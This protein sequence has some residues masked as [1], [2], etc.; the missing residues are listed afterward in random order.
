[1][2]SRYFRRVSF[3]ERLYLASERRTPG[4]CI[5]LVV[6]ADGG[7]DE[8]TLRRAVEAASIANPGARLVLRGVLGFTR[9]VDEGP[10]PPVRI[11]EGWRSGARPPSDVARVLDPKTGPTC[12]V[13]LAPHEQGSRL[14]FR[15]FH[16]VMD[17]SGLLHFAQDV[18]RALRGE[19]PIGAPCM[20]NDTEFVS[21]LA[22]TKRRSFL[23]DA[24]PPL[25]GP[26]GV[27]E[28][29]VHWHRGRLPS[30]VPSLV[31]KVATTLARFAGPTARGL[32]MVP[33]DLRSYRK[34][35]ASTANRT[36]PVFLEVGAS[37]DWRAVQTSLLKRLIAKEPLRLEVAEHAALWFPLWLLSALYG[38]WVNGHR[39]KGLFPFT[40]LVTHVS[41]PSHDVLSAGSLRCR[42]VFLLPPESDFIPL[43]ISAV[44]SPA[45]TELVVSGPADLV[46]DEKLAALC[47]M[48]TRELS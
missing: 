29:S 20:Q 21:A 3:N 32:M 39:R 7:V 46:S 22:G 19:T 42:S 37:D 34:E 35:P 33:V 5:Q 47:A 11:L 6:E 45:S 24:W 4:F 25:L 23:A 10:V 44:T 15:C 12:E 2:S 30:A 13:V 38:L 18:F 43:C 14:V 16:G 1:M 27:P 26:T 8:Q 28:R 31:A 36:C 17:A 41:L 40:A 48:L 9:W